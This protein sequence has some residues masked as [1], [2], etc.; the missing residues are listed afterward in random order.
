[1]RHQSV[2][3]LEA[4]H[5]TLLLN[6]NPRDL[7]MFSNCWILSSFRVSSLI[8]S[9]KPTFHREVNTAQMLNLPLYVL[10]LS[11]ICFEQDIPSTSTPAKVESVS[12][13]DRPLTTIPRSGNVTEPLI[14]G[15]DLLKVS[16]FGVKD[17]DEDVRVSSRGDIT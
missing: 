6:V 5:Q 10:L 11:L 12:S 2:L 15:G 4:A 16:V 1:M 7:R 13:T 3:S 8:D 17:F 14:G 9:A